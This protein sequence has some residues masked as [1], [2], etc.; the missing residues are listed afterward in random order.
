MADDD[1]AS[2]L[3][4]LERKL[5]DL[6]DELRSVPRGATNGVAPAAPAPAPSFPPDVPVTTPT[7]SAVASALPTAPRT[8]SPPAPPP[9][10]PRAAAPPPVA[11]PPPDA[12]PVPP[13][14]VAPVAPAPVPAP[15]LGELRRFR[16]EL[17]S[18][19]R[20]FL[21]EYERV[22]GGLLAPIDVALAAA[23]A[24]AAPAPR[25]SDPPQ[26]AE[27]AGDSALA[28]AILDGTVAV[29]AGPF[30][31]I[32][33]LSCFEQALWGVQ[34]VHDVHVRRF[35]GNRAHIDVTLER[36][37]ALGQELRRSAPVVFTVIEVAVGRLSIAIEPGV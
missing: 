34:G 19:A 36:P 13:A 35:E 7:P 6:E 2:T 29:D 20:A 33:T 17:E 16:E 30:A 18:S 1:V 26:P 24:P 21:A 27:H 22:V 14:A 10:A 28:A 3:S 32:A 15:E 11:A 5:K 12:A 9:V 23:A 8:W 37:V 25:P 4:E 31:D